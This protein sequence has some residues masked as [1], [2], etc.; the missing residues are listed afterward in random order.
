MSELQQAVR[1]LGPAQAQQEPAAPREAAPIPDSA[2]KAPNGT[3][4]T[5]GAGGDLVE[6]DFSRRTYHPRR[7]LKSTDGIITVLYDPVQTV[8]MQDTKGSPVTLT[9]AAPK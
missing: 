9:F 7:T 5:G 1:R 4:S 2:G 3:P 6:K 8:V